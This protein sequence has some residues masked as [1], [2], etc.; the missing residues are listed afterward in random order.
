MVLDPNAEIGFTHLDKQ[1]KAITI[2]IGPEGGLSEQEIQQAMTVGYQPVKLGPRVL[3]TETAT[4]AAL[5]VVQT[6]WGD[7]G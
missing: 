2:L 3:R 5:A 4:A 6:L 1:E 7:L